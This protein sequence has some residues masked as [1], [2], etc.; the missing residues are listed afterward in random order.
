MLACFGQ[1]ACDLHA[2]MCM[3]CALAINQGMVPKSAFYCAVMHSMW[4][5]GVVCILCA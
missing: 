2:V 4:L 1:R 5:S 3:L